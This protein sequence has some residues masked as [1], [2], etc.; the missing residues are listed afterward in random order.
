M[1]EC[2]TDE[3]EKNSGRGR[4]C[5]YKRFNIICMFLKNRGKKWTAVKKDSMEASANSLNRH[6][7][8]KGGGMF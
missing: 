7:T 6:M 1:G 4:S 8:V 3:A 2:K 5:F